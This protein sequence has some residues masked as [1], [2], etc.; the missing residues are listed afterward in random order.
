[1]L[2]CFSCEDESQL[3]AQDKGEVVLNIDTNGLD[4]LSDSI[5]FYSIKIIPLQ[6]GEIVTGKINQ[7]S[8]PYPLAT[9]GYQIEIVSPTL[10]SKEDIKYHYSGESDTFAIKKEETRIVPITLRISEFHITKQEKFAPM[11][12]GS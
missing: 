5:D 1:M 7:L 9:G 2:L 6:N 12:G 10:Y 8:W 11:K 4:I 3:D